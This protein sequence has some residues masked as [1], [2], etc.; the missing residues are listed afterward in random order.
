V[1]LTAAVIATVLFVVL[2]R[3]KKV[4]RAQAVTAKIVERESVIV[5]ERSE[6]TLVQDART[7]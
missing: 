5:R 2:M 1:G 6:A 4:K 3:R 7:K